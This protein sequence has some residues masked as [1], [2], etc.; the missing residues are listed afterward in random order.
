MHVLVFYPLSFYYLLNCYLLKRGFCS[1][2][3]CSYLLTEIILQL[4][5]E[6][7]VVT[8]GFIVVTN[9]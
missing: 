6:N 1:M 4:S 9:E 2:E 5:F 8:L 7:I 3:L